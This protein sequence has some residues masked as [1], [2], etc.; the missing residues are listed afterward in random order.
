MSIIV[1]E[2]ESQKRASGNDPSASLHVHTLL[3]RTGA[4]EILSSASELKGWLNGLSFDSMIGH[5]IRFNGI[6]R[7]RAIK[8]RSLD[9][10]NVLIGSAFGDT[11]YLA[12]H[13]ADKE[14]LLQS[15][16]L[17]I[18]SLDERKDIAMLSYLGIQAIHPFLDGNG[19]LGR[20][21]YSLFGGE[22]DTVEALRMSTIPNLIEHSCE[23][24]QCGRKSFCITEE[25]LLQIY[26]IINRFC[27]APLYIPAEKLNGSSRIYSCLQAGTVQTPAN[28][29][30]SQ[31]TIRSM[32]SAL[33]Q[34]TPPGWHFG[35]IAMIHYLELNGQTENVLVR[36]SLGKQ[37]IW[38]DGEALL[39]NLNESQVLKIL[40][41]EREI[42]KVFVEK[43]IDIF[44][45]PDSYLVKDKSLKEWIH[46]IAERP[47]A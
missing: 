43:M 11:S 2:N 8:E 7:D 27:V 45:E 19:R 31:A 17:T 4:A 13:A 22:P 32:E 44:K 6:V 25:K 15:M 37:L 38:F 34:S 21:A 33:G 9:G 28:C 1:L 40:G 12:P 5:L 18:Q 39:E 46:S 36:D 26:G 10:S 24:D 23:M 20:L 29:T 3:R 35:D 16:L 14:G 30:W 42:K 47:N 41:I